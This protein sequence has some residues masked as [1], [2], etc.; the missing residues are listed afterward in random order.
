[1]R[2]VVIARSLISAILTVAAM[3]ASATTAAPA[4]AFAIMTFT[5]TFALLGGDAL[6]LPGIFHQSRAGS[7]LFRRIGLLGAERVNWRCGL[8]RA[9]VLAASPTPAAPPAPAAMAVVM[10]GIGSR[11]R[12]RLA[13][14]FG[15]GGLLG[16]FL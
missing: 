16:A 11:S 8:T 1:L 5:M 2:T 10:F 4:P 15:V 6:R 3:P 12:H 13:R 14:L 7:V 9:A